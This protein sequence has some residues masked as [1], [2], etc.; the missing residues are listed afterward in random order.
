MSPDDSPSHLA[1]HHQYTQSH[2]SP[3]YF[4]S[5]CGSPD[6]GD[7]P[8]SGRSRN[9][10][11]TEKKV[12]L[13]L[14]H[15]YMPHVTNDDAAWNTISQTLLQRCGQV[16]GVPQIKQQVRDLKKKFKRTCTATS[17][18]TTVTSFEFHDI[19]RAIFDKQEDMERSPL[20]GAGNSSS[21][22]LA[23]PVSSTSSL[24]TVATLCSGEP[25]ALRAIA[26]NV[27]QT[28][29]A[30]LSYLPTTPRAQP[31]PVSNRRRTGSASPLERPSHFMP[32]PLTQ[33][34][35]APV[36]SSAML[37]TPGASPRAS[38]T[39]IPPISADRAGHTGPLPALSLAAAAVA[40]PIDPAFARLENELGELRM[41][42]RDLDR[43]IAE[44]T[45]RLNEL[46]QSTLH[47]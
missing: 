47:L 37:V 9:W 16:W 13:G 39:I 26:T 18:T 29:T 19:I 30:S 36:I 41:A 23:A 24:P 5:R 21:S 28:R 31:Y 34:S 38:Y 46:K 3:G 43:R 6:V 33:T 11:Y 45:G 14:V 44:T 22:D 15:A 32:I 1:T 42:Q 7:R 35:S 40:V 4:N 27:R 10:S 20:F 12:L 17:S 25:L 2:G 8:K